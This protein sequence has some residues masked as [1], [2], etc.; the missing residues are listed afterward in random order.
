[1]ELSAHIEDWE[2]KQPFRIAGKE[3]RTSTALVVQLSDEKFVGR[4]EGQGVY[5]LGETSD[6]QAC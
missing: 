2:L 3:W 1:M 4:G 5:Y 6:S